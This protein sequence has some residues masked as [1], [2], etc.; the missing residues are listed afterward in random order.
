MNTFKKIELGSEGVEYVKRQLTL[1]HTLAKSLLAS[2]DIGTGRVFTILPASTDD[3][4]AK[5]FE[6]GGK[7]PS[8]FSPNDNDSN[9]EPVP[10]TDSYLVD[11]VRTFLHE[12]NDRA[13]VFEDASAAPGD[14]YL[15][16]IETRISTMN[17]E[18]YHLLC[19]ADISND[20]ILKTIRLARS[21][22]F[23]GVMTYSSTD[24]CSGREPLTLQELTWL[25]QRAEKI[26]IGAYDGE[27]YLTWEKS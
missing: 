9:L 5:D 6:S 22:L 14:P 13:C 20:K 18:V 27:G 24:L 2:H 25:A 17:Q 10:N 21:W 7:L 16:N 8:L 23:I 11:Q 19:P 1:G 4:A 15:R 12:G 3:A 26:V